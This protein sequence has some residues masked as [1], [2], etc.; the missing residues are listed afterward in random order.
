[1]RYD[2]RHA[3]FEE[4][5]ELEENQGYSICRP[6]KI[7]WGLSFQKVPKL[8]QDEVCWMYD[9]YKAGSGVYLKPGTFKFEFPKQAEPVQI[10]EEIDENTYS[11]SFRKIN[12]SS[13]SSVNETAEPYCIGFI[14]QIY[15]TTDE[16]NSSSDSN[17]K[18]LVQKLYRP[19]NTHNGVALSQK[20]DRNML[21]WSNEQIEIN[22]STVTGK[23]YIINENNLDIPTSQ[24]SNE[25]PDRF[26]YSESYDQQNKQFMNVSGL[27]MSVG[28]PSKGKGGK[29]KGK[30]KYQSKSKIEGTVTAPIW[31]TFHRPMNM[32]D[33]FAG[34]GGL[35]EGLEQSGVGIT[36]W[37]VEID[38][39]A[40][41][42][43]RMN[44]PRSGVY[45]EDCNLLLSLAVAGIT[46]SEQG[47]PIPK[48]GDVDLICG[49]PPIH[50]FTGTDS[51]TTE[52]YSRFSTSLIVSFLS[53]CDFYRPSYVILENI[54]NFVLVKKSMILKLTLRCLTA[55]GYQ[56]TFGVLQAGNFGLPQNRRRLFIL[57]AA[58]GT[59]LPAFPE[60]THAFSKRA[61]QLNVTVENKKFTTGVRWRDG[62]PYRTMTVRDAMSDLPIISNGYA[63]H[64][65]EYDSSIKSHYQRLLRSF[66]DEIL[67][68]HV[69][70]NMAPI[71][72]TRMENIPTS[73]GSDWRDLPNI[74]IKLSDGSS[75]KK[76][77]Y[78]YHDKKNGMNPFGCLRG[79]CPCAN[80]K[81]CNLL[82][83]QEN[84]FIPWCLS[85]TANKNNNWP[86]LYGRLEWDGVFSTTV[87][88][89]EPTG[90]EGPVLHPAQNRVVSV[91]ECARSQGFPDKY[92]FHGNT[93]EKYRQIGNA[94]PPPVAAAIG[95]ELKKAY[96][97]SLK[98]RAIF[99]IGYDDELSTD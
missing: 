40:S 92:R 95:L 63:H 55:M 37:A 67:Y 25:G 57:A 7:N 31:P 26:Y 56:C 19:E 51:F 82:E 14:V 54:R 49:G 61:L 81:P 79:V 47:I 59:P 21:F 2:S 20:A 89:P 41:K 74:E 36:K 78:K 58:P 64:E 96:E 33:I 73:L 44:H 88:N 15:P 93:T 65:I 11:E 53:Y 97:K 69:C 71:I 1:M 9:R 46:H 28:V 29:V 30:G 52:Q 77:L 18:L 90:R 38:A 8:F 68:D 35:S 17:I 83:I 48:R 94:V 66:D 43:F 10:E 45:T 91:R 60:P 12:E 86:G 32:L 13:K 6:C 24:W 16:T 42:T 75:A 76:L 5:E 99:F 3:R 80:G 34:C 4:V 22:F 50:D 39:A 72:L 98:T 23:C 27:G 85:H 62:A 87:T 70:K 84:T